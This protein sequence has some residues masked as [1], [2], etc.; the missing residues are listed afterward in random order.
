MKYFRNFIWFRLIVNESKVERKKFPSFFLCSIQQRQQRR[1]KN[2]E[3][4]RWTGS[5]S[6]FNSFS[7]V[8]FRWRRPDWI[9]RWIRN[10]NVELFVVWFSS[11]EES[12]S[13]ENFSESQ[14]HATKENEEI[15]PILSLWRYFKNNQWW[16]RQHG[17]NFLNIRFGQMFAEKRKYHIRFLTSII[18]SNLRYP[19]EM[20]SSSID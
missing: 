11:W 12:K 6:T 14:S 1:K 4:F 17:Q 3:S 5:S 7:Q 20:A 19:A 15:Q 9:C 18:R 8:I 16:P 2:Q 13:L 10:Q